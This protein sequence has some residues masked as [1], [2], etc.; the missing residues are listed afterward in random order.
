MATAVL[1]WIIVIM[2]VVS[3]PAS[4]EM[5]NENA[6]AVDRTRAES[7][8]NVARGTMAL[9]GLVL[10]VVCLYSFYVP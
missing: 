4:S 10:A 1:S 8:F 3:V 7:L 9:V 2:F 5:H 6:K